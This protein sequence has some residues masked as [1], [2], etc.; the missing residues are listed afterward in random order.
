MANKL[1]I[2]NFYDKFSVVN[3]E[4]PKDIIEKEVTPIKKQDLIECLLNQETKS[5]Y[6]DINSLKNLIEN[7]EKFDQY[8]SFKL[9]GFPIDKIEFK[10]FKYHFVFNRVSYYNITISS[11]ENIPYDISKGNFVLSNLI[12]AQKIDVNEFTKRFRLPL[13]I[14]NFFI[15]EAFLDYPIKN[16]LYYKESDFIVRFPLN[17]I[18]NKGIDEISEKIYL[19][20]F[21]YSI[22]S[23]DK[24]I[25]F[26]FESEKNTG[27]HWY[28]T[29]YYK[30]EIDLTNLD[31]KICVTN[32]SK[33][34]Y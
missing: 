22:N 15:G 5:V 17:E 27:K 26:T 34:K 23:F 8:I 13:S 1:K 7:Y 10:S 19:E 31:I 9:K 30:G 29:T 24:K 4:Y 32:T 20:K 16:D 3:R 28:L 18:I 11:F 25:D 21:I 33:Y 14:N 2:V 12:S 6:L